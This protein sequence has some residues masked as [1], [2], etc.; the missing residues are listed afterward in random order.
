MLPYALML[1]ADVLTIENSRSDNAM[2][3]AL[4]QSKCVLC[5]PT[6]L[7]LMHVHAVADVR[8]CHFCQSMVCVSDGVHGGC[9]QTG[10]TRA[11]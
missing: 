10:R 6:Y 8:C 4:A 11:G 3:V 1:A 5:M 9:T 7:F 2:I